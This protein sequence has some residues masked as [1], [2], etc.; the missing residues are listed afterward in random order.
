MCCTASV[1]A[2]ASLASVI[3]VSATEVVNAHN[4]TNRGTSTLECTRARI[5]RYMFECAVLG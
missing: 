5:D 3:F 4:G 1:I 2:R